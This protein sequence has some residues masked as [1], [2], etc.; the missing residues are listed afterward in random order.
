MVFGL[1]FY[2]V[3]LGSFI[4]DARMIAF[5]VE[6]ATCDAKLRTSC[7]KSSLES[8]NM[9]SRLCKYSRVSLVCLTHSVN[10][11][12][13]KLSREVIPLERR[14]PPWKRGHN[15]HHSIL[16]YD[17]HGT[18]VGAILESELYS[19]EQLRRSR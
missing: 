3:C 7:H 13:P 8:K 15:V 10:S 12:R 14:L 6:R 1:H 11:L 16:T 9:L 17:I 19:L 5:G 4:H 2:W 18:I